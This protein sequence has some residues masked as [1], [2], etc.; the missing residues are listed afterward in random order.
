MRRFGYIVYKLTFPN[1]KIYIGKDVG[2]N[3]P[4]WRYF[5][6]WN[7]DLVAAD[8][9]DEELRDFTVRKE[10]IFE[11]YDKD[12]VNKREVEL[13]KLL[14]SNDPKKAIIEYLNLSLKY[15]VGFLLRGESIN[16]MKEVLS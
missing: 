13:I 9:T 3:A 2:M 7:N 10:I 6:S 4:T 1:G 15:A 12:E 14:K 16:Y 11:S 8:F 5:G